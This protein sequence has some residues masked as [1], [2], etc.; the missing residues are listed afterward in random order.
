MFGAVRQVAAPGA[1]SAVSDCIL[2]E[3]CWDRNDV[4]RKVPHRALALGQVLLFMFVHPGCGAHCVAVCCVAFC[5][6]PQYTGTKRNASDVNEPVA[7]SRPSKRHRL[8]VI[9]N[10]Q[11]WR[12]LR[13]VKVITSEHTVLVV[14]RS[15]WASSVFWHHSPA[16]SSIFLSPLSTCS[17]AA[18]LVSLRLPALA[19][20]SVWGQRTQNEDD[21]LRGVRLRSLRLWYRAELIQS[22]RLSVAVWELPGV[23]GSTP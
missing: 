3:L 21:R 11:C 8:S 14:T 5:R 10:T 7:T 20:A 22:H 13:W 17:V 15:G 9:H 19:G 6:I 4:P 2:F 1:K 18:H 12:C 23:G 16:C